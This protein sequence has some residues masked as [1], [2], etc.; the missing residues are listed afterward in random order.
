MAYNPNIPQPV[1]N[2]A[3]SQA[4]L[5]ANFTAMNTYLSVDHNSFNTTNTGKHK[6]VTYL[7][8]NGNAATPDGFIA[9][10]NN[11]SALTG[12]PE[13]FKVNSFGSNLV[14][15]KQFEFTGSGIASDGWSYLPSGLIIK[16]G[17]VNLTG[18]TQ[19]TFP[20]GANIPPFTIFPPWCMITVLNNAVLDPNIAATITGINLV[21]IFVVVNGRTTGN[22]ATS[23]VAYIAIGI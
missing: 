8:Q 13:L 6:Q 9:F 2:I 19:I 5:L 4:D 3:N 21:E 14:Q 11:T 10:Y 1:N 17:V 18:N 12:N 16:W 20:T 15:N 23:N 7:N 22:S